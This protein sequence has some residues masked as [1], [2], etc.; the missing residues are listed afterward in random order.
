MTDIVEWLIEYTEYDA[1]PSHRNKLK[2]AA[3]TIEA[4]RAE[5]AA[6]KAENWEYVARSY[7]LINML[8][9]ETM[10]GEIQDARR[11]F[12]GIVEALRAENAKLRELLKPFMKENFPDYFDDGRVIPI[13]ASCGA[14]RAARVAMGDSDE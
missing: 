10:A 11:V 3:D 7:A 4:L 9:D 6:L 1:D 14:I 13:S 12:G 8:P 5:N 2:E